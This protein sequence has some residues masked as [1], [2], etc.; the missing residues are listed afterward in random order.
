MSVTENAKSKWNVI[1]EGKSEKEYRKLT[2][3]GTYNQKINE[4][5]QELAENPYKLAY[6]KIGNIKGMPIL[7]TRI[8]ESIRLT[9]YPDPRNKEVYILTIGSHKEA[10][11]HD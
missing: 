4:I 1:F 6:E 9:Y 5:L 2:S 7:S 3:Y 11:D 10:Y 8:N